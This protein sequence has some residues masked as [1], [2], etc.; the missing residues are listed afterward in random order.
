MTSHS[1]W[2]VNSEV[3]NLEHD[4]LI[5]AEKDWFC[6][7][8]TGRPWARSTAS[9]PSSKSRKRRI[10]MLVNDKQRG[11]WFGDPVL[12]QMTVERMHEHRAQDKIVQGTWGHFLGKTVRNFRGCAIGCLIKSGVGILTDNTSFEGYFIEV[13]KHFNIHR[14]VARAIERMFEAT[15]T[16][17][18]AA[19]FAVE[20]VEAIAV[21]ANL[22]EVVAQNDHYNWHVGTDDW[23]NAGPHSCGECQHSSQVRH[24]RDLF[25]KELANAPLMP[26]VRALILAG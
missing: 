8:G 13:E 20:S 19:T 21:G 15:G 16:F 6:S 23:R 9:C 17:E 11:A 26:A 18:E 22:N 4:Y 7:I 3:G 5:E 25:L 24:S 1:R 14:D 12:K 10:V 2:H